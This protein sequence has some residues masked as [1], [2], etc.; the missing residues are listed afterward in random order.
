MACVKCVLCI[1][2]CGP[3]IVRLQTGVAHSPVPNCDSLV[4]LSPDILVYRIWSETGP[5][6][7]SL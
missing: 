2:V 6:G 4:E 1:C 3:D 7:Q 5:S